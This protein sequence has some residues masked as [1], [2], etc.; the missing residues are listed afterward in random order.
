MKKTKESTRTNLIPEQLD[1]LFGLFSPQDWGE[2]KPE[3]VPGFRG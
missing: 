1:G 2:T 3:I